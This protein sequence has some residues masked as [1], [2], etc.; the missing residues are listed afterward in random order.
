MD[1]FYNT[2]YPCILG[3]KKRDGNQHYND[4]MYSSNIIYNMLLINK[5]VR[6]IR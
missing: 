1:I 5:I 2:C 4:Q 3:E 6:L